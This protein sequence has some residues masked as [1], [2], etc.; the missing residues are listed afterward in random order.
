MTVQELIQSVET[1]GWDTA[2]IIYFVE[3]NPAYD[4]LVAPLFQA[5]STGQVHGVTSTITLAEVLI[6]PLRQGDTELAARYRTLLS[7]SAYFQLVSI[8]EAVAE[9]AADIRSDYNLRLPDALQIAAA[10]NHG[11]DVFLTNDKQLKKV[12]NIQVVCSTS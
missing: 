8:D 9:R 11:C 5:I 2:P 10:L 7:Q 1:I 4:A 3:A 6:Y 12:T